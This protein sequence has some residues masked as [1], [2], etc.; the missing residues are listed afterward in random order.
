MTQAQG[1]GITFPSK[2]LCCY[3]QLPVK[4]QQK[5]KNFICP[6]WIILTIDLL[7]AGVLVLLFRSVDVARLSFQDLFAELSQRPS[8]Q[9]IKLVYEILC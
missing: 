7:D 1:N 9:A 6:W 2:F 8:A 3:L 4:R 5:Q